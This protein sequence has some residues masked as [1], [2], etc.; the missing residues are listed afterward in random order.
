MN[1]DFTRILDEFVGLH[2]TSIMDGA[3]F[4]ACINEVSDQLKKRVE[5]P[6]FIYGQHVQSMFAYVAAELGQCDLINEEDHGLFFY[7][8]AN[9]MRRPDFRLHT[10]NGEQ[11][12]VEVK[13][14]HKGNAFAPFK[15]KASYLDSLQRYARRLNTTLYIAIYWSK[16]KKWTLINA[17][18]FDTS[19]EYIQ[20]SLENA[21]IRNEMS[22]IGDYLIGTVPPLSLRIYADPFHDSSMD[23]EGIVNFKIK[24][25]CMCADNKEIING[26]EEHIAWILMLYGNWTN[27]QKPARIENKKLIYFDI[28]VYP[29]C[30]D[31]NNDFQ[32]MG[33][34]SEI[35]SRGYIEM[36]AK[37]KLITR[38]MPNTQPVNFKEIIPHDYH[39]TVL[40][41]W[42]FVQKTSPSVHT[43]G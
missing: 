21:M 29:E 28:E 9:D 27:I 7:D 32:L 17:D 1:C 15:I 18:Y 14:I 11:F 16:L 22:L 26:N 37:E 34:I 42:R 39:G 25:V 4:E 20:L 5:T 3:S 10:R 19:D 2:N 43:Q 6:T 41:L 40:R 8:D 36:T 30:N 13:N 12:L 31:D 33:S 35:I 38:L 24:R 23:D